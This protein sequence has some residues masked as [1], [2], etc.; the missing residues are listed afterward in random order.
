MSRS[1]GSASRLR[2]ALG[3][4][5]LLLA[6]GLLFAPPALGA[7]L[8][9]SP[10][11]LPRPAPRSRA[12]DGNQDDVA[13]LVDWQGL[14][15]AGR[16]RHTA[17]ANDEDTAFVGGSKEDEPGEWD[18]TVEPGGVNPGKANIRDAWSAVDQDG[19]DTFVYLGFARD[20]A[21]ST[22]GTAAR[23]SS[24]SSST[25]TPA[26]GTTGQATIPCRR[27]GDILVSYEPHGNGVDVVLQRWITT[28]D[29]P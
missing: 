28:A 29:R 1:G 8:P 11:P 6:S 25:T 2:R 4:G 23:R 5:L 3:W 10:G 18:F 16:V 21:V 20:S 14:Q 9:P 12:A 24:R 13:P 19:A 27:T 22:F 17:D 26:C 7:T 15:A